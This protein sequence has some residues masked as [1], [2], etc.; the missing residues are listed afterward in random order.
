M[1]DVRGGVRGSPGSGVG[2]L[3]DALLVTSAATLYLSTT[4][5]CE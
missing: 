4:A 2:D 5:G 3:G 1:I